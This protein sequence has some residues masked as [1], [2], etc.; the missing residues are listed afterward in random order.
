MLGM[1]FDIAIE[2]S[3]S[4]AGGRLAIADLVGCVPHFNSYYPTDKFWERTILIN[5]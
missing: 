5:S 4:P 2:R 3:G 1:Q